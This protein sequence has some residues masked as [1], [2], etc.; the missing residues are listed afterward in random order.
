MLLSIDY[1]EKYIG[2]ALA[3]SEARIATPYKTIVRK[4]SSWWK[5]L[6]D[7]V[8]REK[9]TKIIIGHPLGLNSSSTEQTE[10]I[11]TFFE[12]CQQNFNLPIF[13]FDERM[14]SKMAEK[15]SW[16]Q[17]KENHAIAASIILQDY[18]DRFPQD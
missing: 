15:F 6:N 4:N 9:I 17:K 14:T 1:G 10:K 13:L 3:S 18:L 12:K 7:I 11:K 2:L 8:L 16:P 5:E